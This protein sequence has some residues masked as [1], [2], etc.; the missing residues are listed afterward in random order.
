M[1]EKVPLNAVWPLANSP[2]KEIDPLVLSVTRLIVKLAPVKLS[3]ATAAT[4]P[5]TNCTVETEM[6]VP[7]WMPVSNVPLEPERTCCRPVDTRLMFRNDRPSNVVASGPKATL[8]PKFRVPARKSIEVAN[9]PL[10]NDRPLNLVLDAMTLISSSRS[11][12]SDCRVWRRVVSPGK[13]LDADSALVRISFRLSRM[14]LIASND[15]CSMFTP[16]CVFS[17]A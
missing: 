3:P 13:E 9:D 11:W 8:A 14:L 12:I 15:T 7:S 6:S 16:S 4:P 1:T 10:S 2:L 5:L 17:E